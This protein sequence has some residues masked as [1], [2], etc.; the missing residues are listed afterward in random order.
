MSDEKILQEQEESPLIK[1][2]KKEPSL[3]DPQHP[4]LKDFREK[5]NSTFTHSKSVLSLVESVAAA[6]DLDPEYLK[7]AAMYHDLGKTIAPQFFTENQRDVNP[8]D[9]I[10][11]FV[12]YLIITRHVS[13]SVT[14]LMAHNFPTKVVK[15]V[16][17]HHGTCVLKYFYDKALKTNPKAEESLFRYKTEKPTCIESMILML[18]DHVEAA[19][20]SIFINRAGG[21]DKD[22]NPANLITNIFSSLEADKQF[23]NVEIKAYGILRKIK[24]ALVEDISGA[25][26]NRVSYP[27]DEK[28]LEENSE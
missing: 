20:R 16:S 28:L 21:L 2:E 11:P 26:H 14:F 10:D 4:L 1:E 23:D 15:I 18:C 3:L 5:A 8:H 22:F 12:S 27:D 24:E 19:S 9:S 13:D 25:Y 6:I 7:L 17:Q